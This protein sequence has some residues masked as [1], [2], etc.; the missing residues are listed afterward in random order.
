M[1]I[2]NHTSSLRVLGLIN[3]KQLFMTGT[4]LSNKDDRD[5]LTSKLGQLREL[6]LDNNSYLSDI[7]L[8]RITNTLSNLQLIR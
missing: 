3:C 8:L 7:L 5:L 4:F 6:I 2:I 1:A